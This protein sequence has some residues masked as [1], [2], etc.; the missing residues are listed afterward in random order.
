MFVPGETEIIMRLE[1]G[2]ERNMITE[3]IR[4]Y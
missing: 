3:N 4:M 1:C 2:Q